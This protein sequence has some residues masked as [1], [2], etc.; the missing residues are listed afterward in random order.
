[1]SMTISF[2]VYI[3]F[4]LLFVDWIVNLSALI[5]QLLY[6]WNVLEIEMSIYF[7]SF[8]YWIVNL[9]ALIKQFYYLQNVLDIEMS[10][11]ISFIINL[12]FFLLFL[13]WKVNPWTLIFILRKGLRNYILES[14]FWI[15]SLYECL[16]VIYFQKI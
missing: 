13:Y 4:I 11:T 7:T 16:W 10:M 8:L 1:M 9:W 6:L 2:I 5:K 15:Q 3:L 12:I 14:T